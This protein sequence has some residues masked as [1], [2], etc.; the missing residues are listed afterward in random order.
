MDLC[1]K[2]CLGQ[3]HPISKKNQGAVDATSPAVQFAAPDAQAR[4]FFCA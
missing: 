4:H 1:K 3:S 2:K